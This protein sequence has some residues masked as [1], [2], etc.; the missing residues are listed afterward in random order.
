MEE[1]IWLYFSIIAIIMAVG[2]IGTLFV[3]NNEGTQKQHF[4]RSLTEL[5]VQCNYVCDSGTGT[6]FPVDI[7][8]PSGLYF[9]TKNNKICGIFDKESRCEICDCELNNFTMDLNTSFARDVLS[10]HEYAC[11]FKRTSSGVAIDCQG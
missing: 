10:N 8:F 4:M 5:Q 2:V 7:I 11:F 9:Y 1:S 3:K 6:N